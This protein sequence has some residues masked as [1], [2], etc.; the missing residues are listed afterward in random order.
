MFDKYIQYLKEQKD[1]DTMGTEETQQYYLLRYYVV[2]KVLATKMKKRYEGFFEEA[3]SVVMTP[4]GC[5]AY[6]Y[7][8]HDNFSAAI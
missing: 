8:V 5:P 6:V 3:D 2:F 4:F 7:S 1:V